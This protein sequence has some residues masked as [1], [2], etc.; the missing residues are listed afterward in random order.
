MQTFSLYVLEK[1]F[2]NFDAECKVSGIRYVRGSS[3]MKIVFNIVTFSNLPADLKAIVGGFA[4]LKLPYD[5]YNGNLPKATYASRQ[6][7][8]TL[9]RRLVLNKNNY[10]NLEQLSGTVTGVVPD[11]SD[12]SRIQQVTVRTSDGEIDIDAALVVG[13]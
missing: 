4:T 7:L 11:P 13:K 8:E 6:G 9:L 1:L 10:P 12:R 2:P 3:A 5:E